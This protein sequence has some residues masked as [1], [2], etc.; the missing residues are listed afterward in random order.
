MP[1][2]RRATGTA[3]YLEK[4]LGDKA[5]LAGQMRVSISPE[6]TQSMIGGVGK[7]WLDGPRL[8]LL[9][10]VDAIHQ[11]FDDVPGA[12]RGQL[13]LHAGATWM[14][15]RGW[16]ASAILERF[17]EDLAIEG[18]ARTAGS[19]QLQWFP[20]AHVELILLGRAQLMGSFDQRAQLL[21]LQAHY[22][23]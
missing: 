7:L 22:Y 21:M 1:V 8:L 5:A 6:D 23:L 17:D 20:T 9:G 2:G 18:V 3:V 10:Q 13:V 14:P 4:R 19:L 11:S 12:S 16:M 15:A